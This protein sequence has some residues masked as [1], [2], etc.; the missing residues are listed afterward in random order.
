[1][2]PR[3]ALL[4][5][6]LAACS[7]HRPLPAANAEPV[8]NVYNWADFIEPSV[9]ADFEKEYGIK[10]HYDVYASNETME[11]KLLAG[12]S[13]YDLVVPGGAFFEKEIKAG[14]YQPLDKRLLPNLPNLDPGAVLVTSVYDP[15]NRYGVDY[16]WLVATG[17]GYDR[18]KL[19]ARV[20]DAPLTSW[21]LVFD[22]TILAKLRDCGVSLLDAPED[23]LSAT[24]AYLGKDP[25]SESLDDLD[26]AATVWMT[27][28]PYIRYFDSSRYFEDLA[29]GD[30]CLALGWSGDIAQARLRARQA[31]KPATIE[32]VL[33]REGSVSTA[34]VLAIPADAPHPKNAH[35]FI[36]YL[37]RPEVAARNSATVSYASGV[38]GA[39]ALLPTEIRSEQAV[40]PPA[41]VRDRLVTMRA[42]T[43]EFTRAMM[44]AWT[45]FKTGE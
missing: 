10:V 36:N 7:Q 31:G 28:R 45:R 18:A 39:V 16:M 29:N 23:V 6:V 43:P 14:V 37:L 38:A 34:D 32:Y 30:L 24:L 21:R 20:P 12:H 2:R 4:G 11:V 44:R 35:V 1:M 41:D 25:R 8:L 9:I 22:P 13:S 17:I 15:G 40:Y 33:P 42:K 3:A 19:L 26:A 27:I 5:L